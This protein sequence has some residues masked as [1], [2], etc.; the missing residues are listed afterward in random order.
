[1]KKIIAI[2]DIDKNSN[3]SWNRYWN[4][5]WNKK[6]W[7][8]IEKNKYNFAMFFKK[9][10]DFDIETMWILKIWND[11]DLMIEYWI[12]HRNKKITLNW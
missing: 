1:M 2:F 11:I 5:R 7:S 8:F 10:N 12:Y 3:D 6:I 9:I 4:Y